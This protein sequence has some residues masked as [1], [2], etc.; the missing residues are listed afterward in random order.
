MRRRESHGRD[1]RLTWAAH[2]AHVQRRGEISWLHKCDNLCGNLS[3]SPPCIQP[4]GKTRRGAFCSKV[5]EIVVLGPLS[6]AGGNGKAS[7]YWRVTVTA[8]P[9][10]GAPL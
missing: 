3:L 9:W 5:N 2:V 10:Q 1:L 6:E 8:V 4:R 7:L